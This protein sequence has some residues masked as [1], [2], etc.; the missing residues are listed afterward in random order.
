MPR[1]GL[2]F[3]AMVVLPAQAHS[4]TRFDHLDWVTRDLLPLDH[5]AQ[6]PSFCSGDYLPPFVSDYRWQGLAC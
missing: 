6:L 5:Q 1:L 3:F 4:S 2:L